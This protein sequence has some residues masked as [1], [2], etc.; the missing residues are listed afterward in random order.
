MSDL[1]E[2][3]ALVA[4]V[5]LP[6]PWQAAFEDTHDQLRAE[7]PEGFDPRLIGRAAWESLPEAFKEKALDELFHTYWLAVDREEQELARWEREKPVREQLHKVLGEFA[8]LAQSSS[9]V[10]YALLAEIARLSL[11]LVGSAS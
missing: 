1:T 5:R 9:P 4:E 8:A 7:L 3:N 6:T 2:F 10:P 11:P